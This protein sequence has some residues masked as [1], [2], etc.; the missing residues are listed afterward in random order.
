MKPIDPRLLADSA[1]AR[2]A[3]HAVAFVFGACED[4]I[5]GATRGSKSAARARQAAMYLAHVVFGMSLSRV[6]VA[7]GRDRTTVAHACQV[8]ED[9]RDE[10]AFDDTLERLEAFL[11]AAPAPH[12]GPQR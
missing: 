1:R 11:R 7:F 8:I 5:A 2:L 4:E 12:L 9:M 6:A 3:L 10:T